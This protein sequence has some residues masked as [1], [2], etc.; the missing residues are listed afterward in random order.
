A[1]EKHHLRARDLTHAQRRRRLAPWALDLLLPRLRKPR[2]VVDAGA[3]DDAEHGFGHENSRQRRP[4]SRRP[5]SALAG[6]RRIVMLRVGFATHSAW[7]GMISPRVIIPLQ[8]LALRVIF[9]E[10][11]YPLFGITR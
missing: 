4:R 11:R 9:A 1:R 3:A 8:V 6:P 10:N 5:A 2:Q 7:S